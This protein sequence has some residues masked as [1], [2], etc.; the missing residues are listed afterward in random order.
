MSVAPDVFRSQ[1]KYLCRDWHPIPLSELAEAALAGA[2]PERAV[3][4][5]FDDGYLDNLQEAAPILAE[6]GVPA[7]F[8]V[9]SEALRRPH[10]FWWD[11]LEQA[12]LAGNAMPVTISLRLD[13]VVRSFCTADEEARRATHDELYSMLKLTL[14]AIRDDLLW[15][16]GRAIGASAFTCCARPMVAEEVR[17]LA[18]MPRVEIGAHSVHH[19]ALPSLEP[20]HLFRE[21]SEC[22][23]A[24]ERA[25][26]GPVT[27]FAYPFGALSPEAVG[28][29]RAA[30]YRFAFSCEERRL[31]PGEHPLRLPRAQVPDSAGELETLL[32]RI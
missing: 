13:G 3:A 25:V 16:L 20:E 10:A 31:R 29:V 26:D 15:Q 18:A 17:R 27:L 11:R 4:L 23:T 6:F 5:A 24:I 28:M 1:L 19:V 30:G 12:F 14:P 22:R 7:T 8:F 21:V 9:T 32:A 2:I